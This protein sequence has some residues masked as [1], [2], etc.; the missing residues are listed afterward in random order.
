MR[1]YWFF[2]VLL[3]SKGGV[4]VFVTVVNFHKELT[5]MF[6]C[7]CSEIVLEFLRRAY[8]SVARVD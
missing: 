8:R 5:E 2:L 7:V 4:E 1:S 3:G 6:V